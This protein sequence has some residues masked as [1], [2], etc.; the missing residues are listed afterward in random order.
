MP[1]CKDLASGIALL[2]GLSS[3]LRFQ[4]PDSLKTPYHELLKLNN[5]RQYQAAIFQG[6]ILIAHAPKFPH[7]YGQLAFAFE[8]AERV[9]QGLAYFDSLR[10]RSPDNAYVYYALAALERSLKNFEQA[11]GSLKA[12]IKL[13]PK[14][15]QAYLQL[16]EVYNEQKDLETPAS[17]FRA[18]LQEDSLNA[19]AH[20]GLGYV[21]NLKKEWAKGEKAFGRSLAINPDLVHAYE[22]KGQSHSRQRDYQKA[23]ETWEQGKEAAAK[24]NDI[25]RQGWMT[26]H[27]GKACY[28]LD[29]FKESLGYLNEALKLAR[30]LDDKRQELNHLT[31]RGSSYKSLRQ[32]DNAITDF[33]L[34]RQIAKEIG[35]QIAQD[36]LLM[37]LSGVYDD[38]GEFDLAIKYAQEALKAAETRGDSLAVASCCQNLGS[39]YRNTAYYSDA[40]KYSNRALQIRRADGDLRSVCTLLNNIGTICRDIGEIAAAIDTFQQALKIAQNI[41]SKR[42]ELFALGGL[43]YA[44]AGRGEYVLASEYW[45]RTLSLANSLDD[46]RFK[47]LHLG[48]LGVI[49][50]KWGR[51]SQALDTLNQALEL[52]RNMKD[53]PSVIR[54]YANIANIFEIRGD[55]LK[56]LELQKKALA[57]SDSIDTRNYSITLLGNM[58][59]AYDKIG[60]EERALFHFEKALQKARTIPVKASIPHILA[61]I[62]SLYERQDRFA[63]ALEKLNEALLI[64]K[65]IDDREGQ[66]STLTTIGVVYERQKDTTKALGTYHEALTLAQKIGNRGDTGE[67][68]LNLANI[69]LHRNDLSQ[70]GALYQKALDAGKEMG[71]FRLAYKAHAGLAAIAEKQN[72]YDEALQYYDQ[73]LDKIESVRERLQIE[74]YKTQFIEDKLEVYESVITLLIRMGEFEKAY[75]YLQRFRS[76][77]FLEMLGPQRFDFA[78]GISKPRLRRYRFWEQKLR[79]VYDRLGA[80]YAKGES[81]RSAKMIATLNDSLQRV[82]QEHE[83]ICEEIRLHHPRAAEAQGLVQPLGLREIQ[84]KVLQPGQT[85]VEYFVG[86]ETVAAFVVQAGSF[87]C[88]ALKIK[89]EELEKETGRLREPFKQVKERAVTNLFDVRYDLKLAQQLYERLFQPIE[90][91]LA[92]NTSLL[93]VPDGVLHY[94]PFEA[95]VTGIEAKSNDPNVIFSRYENAHYL[96][97][98]YALTYTPAASI[99]ALPKRDCESENSSKRKWLGLGSPDFGRFKE[100]A[101]EEVML[102]ASKGLLLAPLSAR[103]VREV[104]SVMQPD[105]LVFLGKAATEDRFKQEA[106]A[107]TGIYLSTHAIV[108]ETQP[109]YSLIALAQDDDDK[110]DGFLHTY[111]AYN[112]CLSAELVVLSA[113][114]TGLGKLSRGEGLIGLTRGFMYAGAPSVL[115]SLWSV[116]E[117]TA[118][119]MS[120][121]YQN[122]KEGM[123]KDEALRQAKLKLMRTRVET[124]AGKMSFA[125]PFLWAP[126]VLV[127]ER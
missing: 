27:A 102:K 2:L 9:E 51:F 115:V 65:E 50:K 83:K 113:C 14:Y 78:E 100:S 75:E 64:A 6:K 89:R 19:A 118:E 80:E 49:Y 123:N 18:L 39:T 21:F 74:S 35:D 7:A 16:A 34:A 31:N 40:L 121:F 108:D 90:K 68:H 48:N 4:I 98:K 3:S 5:T 127:G 47:G 111:E 59:V 13:D 91:Y 1:S 17:Y 10:Q 109:M 8:K 61:N 46:K 93:I 60:D 86:P 119:L 12:C 29:K 52:S 53:L 112:L 92:A 106:S 95:L 42:H 44:H 73:A 120:L 33:E 103:D 20:F 82:Q 36:N 85:L 70:A 63:E 105:T 45:E 104:A 114:E 11:I 28:E 30:A 99:L 84:Q 54:H 94:L 76:R 122:L 26:G 96:V 62:G 124:K 101:G 43:G 72:R 107:A 125:Q 25:E 126:F 56:A 38:K 32:P 116:E 87:H 79:E 58:G 57:I 117:S 69:H 67:L 55:Y 110:E 81:K 77:S 15:E 37:S 23:F 24:L 41:P 71:A 22:L 66:A 97:E 88:E